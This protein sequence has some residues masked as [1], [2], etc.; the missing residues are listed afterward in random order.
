MIHKRLLEFGLSRAA[1][2][3]ALSAATLTFGLGLRPATAETRT[4]VVSWFVLAAYLEE[5]NCPAG[6][7]P[8]SE[9]FFRRDLK[10][11]GETPEKIDEIMNLRAGAIVGGSSTAAEAGAAADAVIFRGRT[12][13]KP[14]H[15]YYYPGSVPDAHIHTIE[16][17]YGYGFNLDGKGASS[18]NSFEDPESHEKGVNNQYFRAVGCHGPERPSPTE[19][20]STM[21]AY[22]WGNLRQSLPA[23]I[24]SVSG[25][26]L[27][28]DGDVTVS[29]DKAMEHAIV[30][31][32][33]K[34]MADK[35]FRID[36]DPRWHNEYRATLKAGEITSHTPSTFK[37]LYDPYWVPEFDVK[38]ARVRF[39][40]KPDG[41]LTGVLG[42][43]EKWRSLYFAYASFGINAEDQSGLDVP[44][45]YH[46]LKRLADAEPDPKTGENTRISAA[47]RIEAV[48]AFAVP[49]KATQVSQAP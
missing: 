27:S 45:T 14:T 46:A 36:P 39:T 38:Q 24:I 5:G 42:G 32:N 43:Y 23:W 4:Y 12:N 9:A 6:L 44:G 16:S 34:V 2:L 22:A 20:Y 47:F 41:S 19:P 8:D 31:A 25:N 15:A 21:W 1:G 26:D 49:L 40:M 37:M 11:V 10:A 3:A 48:P 29:I 33:S 17:N 28:K 13:G 7:N 35:T 18:P 30:D